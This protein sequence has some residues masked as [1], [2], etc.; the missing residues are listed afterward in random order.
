MN[1][2][3]LADYISEKLDK[4]YVR[5]INYVFFSAPTQ[6]SEYESL[7]NVNYKYMDLKGNDHKDT[8]DIGL[9]NLLTFVY[10]K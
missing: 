10:N 9:L 4:N 8:I 1:K 6:D 2:N 5:V 3:L 7:I